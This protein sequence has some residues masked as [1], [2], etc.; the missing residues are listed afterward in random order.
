[1][2]KL[3]L[4]LLGIIVIA[5]ATWFFLPTKEKSQ[6]PDTSD[7]S[8]SMIN[9]E[10]LGHLVKDN[11]GLKPNTWYLVYEAQGAP[12]LTVELLFDQESHCVYNGTQGACPDVLLPSSSLTEIKGFQ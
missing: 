2:K 11:P 7:V 3:L 4:S 12:A 8:R 9:F 5:L 6:I 1:M 10:K